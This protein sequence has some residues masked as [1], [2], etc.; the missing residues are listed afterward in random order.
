MRSSSH[1]S[2]PKTANLRLL[3]IACGTEDSLIKPNRKL[4]DF[5]KTKEM[6]VTQIETPG[7][8]TGWSGATTWFTSL[9]FSSSRNNRHT[10]GPRSRQLLQTKKKVA[11]RIHPATSVREPI[12]R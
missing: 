10:R 5:L 7:L 9:R 3:W 8:H 2:T 12:R 6:P 1:R 11:L 4:V